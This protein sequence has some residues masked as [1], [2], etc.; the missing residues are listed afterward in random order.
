[1]Y[2]GKPMTRT[3]SSQPLADGFTLIE[4]LVVISIIAL[5]IAL[6]LPALSQAR[7][8]AQNIGCMS[9]QRQVM[10]AT[11]LYVDENEGYFP[12]GANRCFTLDTW[13]PTTLQPHVGTYDVFT[14]PVSYSPRRWNT[15][16]ANGQ[17][18]MFYA[19][20]ESWDTDPTA[21]CGPSLYRDRSVTVDGK[22]HRIE[23][24]NINE[25]RNPSHLVGIYETTRDWSG[26]YDDTWY[27]YYP[28]EAQQKK[29][30]DFSPKWKYD[31]TLPGG[32]GKM[33]GGRHF[34]S[35]GTADTDP[36]GYDNMG[37]I[38]GH[39]RSGLSMENLVSEA[40]THS[41]WFPSFPFNWES[42]HWPYNFTFTA[43]PAD[44]EVW[45]VPWW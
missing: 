5:L 44:A 22:R 3:R 24:T 41:Y 11:H 26:H 38:D 36:W 39:V 34:R 21:P 7:Q 25:I 19:G 6:L 4:L 42:K 33:S 16:V 29:A 17:W 31:T 23:A 15:Y 20:D 8:S 45:L 13:W 18:W 14:C 43:R 9:N 30:A 27:G 28:T 35:G 40:W 10:L 1:M 32:A 37:M 2:H 12:R